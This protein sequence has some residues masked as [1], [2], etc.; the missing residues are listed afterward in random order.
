MQDSENITF[1]IFFKTVYPD[2]PPGA[3]IFVDDECKHDGLIDTDTVIKFDHTLCFNQSHQLRINR[4]NNEKSRP[5]N[6][7]YQT[8]ILDK[9]II[10]GVDI[11]NII[12]SRSYNEPVYPTLWAAQNPNLEKI[13][14]AETHFGFN[15]NWRLNFTSPFY[16]FVMDCVS[17]RMNNVSI[18]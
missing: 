1:E 9:I 10:D 8:L 5:S 11:Q 15:G 18:Y 4:Y 12:Y 16:M 7:T 2:V 14:I 6:N 17:G 13:I 3:R